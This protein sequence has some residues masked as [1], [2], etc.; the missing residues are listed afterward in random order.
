M[1]HTIREAVDAAF[2]ANTYKCVLSNPASKEWVYKKINVDLLKGS[3]QVEKFTRTQVFHENLS[4]DATKL[5]LIHVLGADFRQL[6]AWDGEHEFSV[7]VSA[8][9]RVLSS[10]RRVDGSSPEAKSG[11]DRE[12]NYVFGKGEAIQPLIEMGI[13]TES[14]EVVRSMNDKFRQINRF[15]ETIGEE[16]KKAPG[17][18]FSV[19]DLGCGKSYLSFVLYH[20]LTKVRNLNVRMI[21]LDRKADVIEKCS[22]AAEKYGYGGL[23]FQAGDIESFDFP[24]QIDMV[25]TLHA[26]DTA[27]DYALAGAIK[28]RAGLIFSAPC[29]QHELNGQ[30]KSERLLLLTRYGV[31]RERAAALFTDAIRSNLL[32]CCGYRSEAVEFVDLGHTPKNIM[33]KAVYTGRTDREIY[34]KEVEELMREF[35]LAPTLYRLLKADGM[36]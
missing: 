33:I 36:I 18:D 7:K 19:L 35:S 6:N 12:K 24:G 17:G 32:R 27:T 30:M 34:L 1:E 15:I 11:H 26:C 20:Y 2:G 22:R 13:L 3:Y 14:G 31:V 9:G 29:C 16:I 28:K 10:R 4:Y 25:V 23:A 21:G 8:G 5:F